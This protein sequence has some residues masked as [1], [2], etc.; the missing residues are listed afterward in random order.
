LFSMSSEELAAYRVE[1]ASINERLASD[2]SMGAKER[3]ELETT[4]NDLIELLE[5]MASE[6][7]TEGLE[8]K[9]PDDDA[10]EDDGVSLEDDLADLIGM[11]CMAPYTGTSMPLGLDKHA[12]IVL[13][14]D[15]IDP[16]R[17]VMLSVL[18]SHP[19]VA[20]M[21]PCPHFLAD[22][23]RYAEKCKYS[24]GS[25]VA[26]SEIEDYD[27]PDFESLV[28]GTPVLVGVDPLW[29]VGRVTAKDGD[30]LAVR[31][32]RTG[33]E[34][35][36]CIS[37]VL[38]IEGEI[39]VEEVE[40]AGAGDAGASS[41]AGVFAELKK[42]SLGR[43]SKDELGDWQGGGM[44]L[45]LM[46][47]MGYK[48][49]EGLGKRNDGIVHAIQARICPKG[50]SLDAIMEKKGARKMVD[51]K[52]LQRLK[53][54]KPKNA[55]E[56]GIFSFLNRK[57]APGPAPTQRELEEKESKQLKTTTAA[58]LGAQSFE[59]ERKMKELRSKEQKLVEGIKRN[60]RDKS[61]LARMEAQLAAV[62]K[63][64]ASLEGKKGRIAREMDSRS[65]KKKDIF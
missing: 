45:K 60:A 10:D 64:M 29:E 2:G 62:R 28:E 24:H 50:A 31:I 12:A 54:I 16:E 48:K 61:T 53:E 33:A 27:E 65:S 51:G 8:I 30:Q 15:G 6:E 13:G 34:V 46:Q 20:A 55:A 21:R 59:T 56:Q 4:R 36:S 38:P 26:A 9:K 44:G 1:L 23:C 5:L 63:D 58:G 39:V 3:A 11:R 47:M 17:G 49:G 57:L 22:S 40:L 35:S 37:A 43:V 25:S 7:T 42:E 41:S 32:L 19:L 14:V 52:S 18:Y